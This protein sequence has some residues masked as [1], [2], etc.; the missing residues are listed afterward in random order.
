[1]A[2]A[3]HLLHAINPGLSGGWSISGALQITNWPYHPNLQ[4]TA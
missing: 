4:F 3:L 2:A 1:M